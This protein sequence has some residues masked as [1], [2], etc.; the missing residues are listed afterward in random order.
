MKSLLSGV[1]QDRFFR[2]VLTLMTGTAI[3]Q[4]IVLAV[5][6]VLTRL[7]TPENFG[8]FAL[9]FSISQLISVF[10]TARYEYAILLPEKDEDALNIVALCLAITILV[11]LLTAVF[12]L[13]FR[14]LIGDL[15]KNEQ[16]SPF[17][18]FMPLTV[19]F[20]GF[21]STINLWFNRKSKFRNISIGKI[22][23]SSFSSFFSIGF[24]LTVFKAAGL[25][26]SDTIG[27]MTA[28]IYVFS[29]F[30]KDEK[31]NLSHISISSMKKQAKRYIHFP[32]YSILSGFLEKGSGQVPIILLTAFFSSSVTGFFSW[33]QRVI[34]A[35][36]GLIS[37]SIG[38]VFRQQASL[39]FQQNGNCRKTFLKL[40]K[41]L[42]TISFIPFVIL[43]FYAPDIFAFIFGEE[44]RMAGNYSQIM[45]VM[46]F[47]SF[48]TSPLSNMFIIAEKQKIDMF[49]QI[50]LFIFICISFLAGYKIFNNPGSAILL[51]TITYSIKYCI[52][53]CLSYKFSKGNVQ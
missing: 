24:G 33:S 51:Y 37:G 3:A 44:W 20:I 14:N 28:A 13:P 47:L 38:D 1:F 4:A 34:A 48:V 17:L 50:L 43:A 45:T 39:E 7:F 35:P 42:V 49:I 36:E 6:P 25:I 41:M 22:I 8:L 9:Y 27:Q 26:I 2:S 18:W 31:N 5:S 11:S 52:E 10:L 21:Y 53:F 19:L 12:I 32:R 29:R 40:F 46:F 23:R 16:L 15:V 30:S